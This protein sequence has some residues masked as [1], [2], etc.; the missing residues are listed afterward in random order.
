MSTPAS[1]RVSCSAGTRVGACPPSAR[2]ARASNR[3]ICSHGVKSSASTPPATSGSLRAVM[4][5]DQTSAR[6]RPALAGHRAAA[7]AGSTAHVCHSRVTGFSISAS[8][9]GIPARGLV[10][11]AWGTV[12]NPPAPVTNPQGFMTNPRGLAVTPHAPIAKPYAPVINPQGFM[13]NPQGLALKPHAPVIIPHAVLAS[14]RARLTGPCAAGGAAS[15]SP[16]AVKPTT[17]RS[18]I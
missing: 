11:G 15:I 13:T 7:S 17:R 12:T 16:T 4:N 5:A 18:S 2:M 14:P 6:L 10:P 9:A 8:A 1:G 3:T